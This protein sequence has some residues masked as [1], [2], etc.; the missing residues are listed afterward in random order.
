MF[1]IFF[2][3]GPVYDFKTAQQSDSQMFAR[4]FHGMLKQGIW[5][6]PSQYEAAFLSFAHDDNDLQKTM[7]ACAKTLRNL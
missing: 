7:D 1:T 4:F 3:E 2:Q 6:A 5:L